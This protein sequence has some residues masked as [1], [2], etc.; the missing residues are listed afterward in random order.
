M[1]VHSCEQRADGPQVRGR[2]HRIG[3]DDG[4]RNW[5]SWRYVTC[6]KCSRQSWRDGWRLL[7]FPRSWHAWNGRRAESSGHAPGSRILDAERRAKLPGCHEDAAIEPGATDSDTGRVFQ[8]SCT[9]GSDAW[10]YRGRCS[11]EHSGWNI[12]PTGH[13]AD[14]GGW[15]AITAERPSWSAQHSY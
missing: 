4:F 13:G 3:T 5:R 15:G 14:D 7:W 1:G 12:T 6:S 10:P 2:D 9:L 11:G 8:P